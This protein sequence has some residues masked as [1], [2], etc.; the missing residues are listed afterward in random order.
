MHYQEGEAGPSTHIRVI[1][2]VHAQGTRALNT[3]ITFRTAL[4]EKMTPA[5]IDSGAT[6]NFISPKLAKQMGLT[7]RKLRTPINIHTVDG[8][9][10]KDG[11]LTDYLLL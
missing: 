4:L 7:P 8:S 9:N 2:T 5:L 11:R 10:H 3:Q 1:R 6:E